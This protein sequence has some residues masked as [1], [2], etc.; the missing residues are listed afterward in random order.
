M[1]QTTTVNSHKRKMS[2]LNHIS[3]FLVRFPTIIDKI[4]SADVPWEDF[5]HNLMKFCRETVK[6]SGFAVEDE[7]TCQKKDCNEGEVE[8]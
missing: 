2:V 4:L 1:D 5:A 8:F 7:H 3:T 6:K